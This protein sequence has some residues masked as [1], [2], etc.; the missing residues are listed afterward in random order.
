MCSG[1]VL[2]GKSI[3]YINCITWAQGMQTLVEGIIQNSV[4]YSAR[5]VGYI[6]HE[7]ENQFTTLT[8]PEKQDSHHKSG[9]T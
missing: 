6:D 7:P 9:P 3:K 1:C 5:P 8:S 2:E 4:E